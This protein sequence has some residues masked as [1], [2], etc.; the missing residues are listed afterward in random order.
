VIVSNTSPLIFLAKIDRLALL[1]ALYGQAIIPQAVIDDIE[2]KETADTER[3]RGWRNRSSARDQSATATVQKQLPSDM[4]SGERAAIGLG[5]ELG[6]D[7]VLLDDQEG[8][9]VARTHDLTVTG[10]IG[11]L[12]EDHG[13]GHITSLRRELDRLVDA[14][15]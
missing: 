6:L 1:S 7:L 10:T 11:G 9:R 12:V 8:R 3:I 5:L 2:A 4:G 13:Q 15:L 14:R